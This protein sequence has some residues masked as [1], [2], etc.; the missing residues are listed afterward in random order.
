MTHVPILRDAK[1]QA[2]SF[3]PIINSR[4][5]GEV[6]PGDDDLFIE[7]TGTDLPMVVLTLNIFAANLADRGATIEP[8]EVVYP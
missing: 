3:P 2:V 4:E 6:R 7:V 1:H 8:I 5:I